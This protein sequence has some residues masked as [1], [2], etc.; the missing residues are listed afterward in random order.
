MSGIGSTINDSGRVYLYDRDCL[1]KNFV[2]QG[3]KFI[4]SGLAVNIGAGTC[5]IGGKL[6]ELTAQANIV[7]PQ[8]AAGLIYAQRNDLLDSPS[9]GFQAAQFPAADTGTVNRWIIDGSATIASTV[10]TNNLTKTGTVNQVDGWIGYGGQGDGATGYYTS[11]NSTGFPTGAAVREVDFVVTIANIT[12]NYTALVGYGVEYSSTAEFEVLI[13]TTGQ[14]VMWFSGSSPNW[15]TGYVVSI[16]QTYYVSVTYDGITVKMYVN[17]QLIGSYVVALATTAGILRIN[18]DAGVSGNGEAGTHIYHYV[19]LRNALRTPAQIAAIS[20]ALCLPCTY[21]TVN[22]TLPTMT[23]NNQ[24]GYVVSASSLYSA[25]YDAYKAFNK[26]NVAGDFWE[27]A[28]G[29]VTG[30][31]KVQFP[32]AKTITKYRLSCPPDSGWTAVM[33]RIWTMEGSNTGAFSGEQTIV[34]ARTETGWILSGTIEYSIQFPAAFLYYRLS[35]TANNG[36]ASALGMAELDLLDGSTNIVDIRSILPPSTIALG[37]VRAGTSA[38]VELDDSSYKYGRREGAT[39]GNR[40]LFLGWVT[41]TAANQT[42]K[43]NNPFG[44]RNIKTSYYIASD[45]NG[46]NMSPVWPATYAA[47]SYGLYSPSVTQSLDP[48]TMI[49]NTYAD[50]VYGY[51]CCYGCYAEVSEAG[52]SYNGVYYY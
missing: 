6:H 40:R 41:A 3:M 22:T 15:S 16:G 20:N 34:D 21:N 43:W 5:D 37:F 32:S 52:Y 2:E 9:V 29:V 36:H 31:V 7:I 33:P 49:T 44:T 17:G 14:F 48:L 19:E 25:A 50:R 13:D 18:K 23:S 47:T 39:G 35:I 11:A 1:P 30:W 4:P 8:R 27:T 28:S 45:T 10:G 38:I 24:N 26:S 51:P 46:R 12:A 42:I